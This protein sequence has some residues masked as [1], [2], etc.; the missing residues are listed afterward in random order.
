MTS[1]LELSVPSAILTDKRLAMLQALPRAMRKLC[2][3]PMH[4][5]N[6][7]TDLRTS[8]Q[9][10]IY[11]STKSRAGAEAQCHGRCDDLSRSWAARGPITGGNA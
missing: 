5:L 4:V 10:W 9:L 1:R 7:R 6:G 8:T 11:L 2:A 3:S